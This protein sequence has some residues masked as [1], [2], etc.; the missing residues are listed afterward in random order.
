MTEKLKSIKKPLIISSIIILLP[1]VAGLLLWGQLPEQVPTHWNINGQID[2]Y[3]SKAFAVFGTPLCMLAVQWLCVLLSLADPK[4]KGQSGK[5]IIMVLWI[6]PAVTLICSG[7]MLTA[8]MGMALPISKLVMGFVGLV[9]VVIGNYLPKCKQN[10]TIGIKTPWSMNDA[11]NWT[12][13]HRFGSK[14]FVV[15]GVV[16]ILSVLLPESPVL[17]CI[18]I[19]LIILAAVATTAYS[20]VYYLRHKS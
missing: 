18:D 14:I 17:Y 19:G 6:I 8:G 2:G 3:S 16:V 20:Y 12:A 1:M 4:N 10:Y 15:C 9:F 5:V 13:T 7:A 11:E